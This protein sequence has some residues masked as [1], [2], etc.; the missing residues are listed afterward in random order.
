MDQLYRFTS[1]VPFHLVLATQRDFSKISINPFQQTSLPSVEWYYTV[2]KALAG[3][4][5]HSR[6]SVFRFGVKKSWIFG[7]H[8][9]RRIWFCSSLHWVAYFV[10]LISNLGNETIEIKTTAHN[11]KSITKQERPIYLKRLWPD[12]EELSN[13]GILISKWYVCVSMSS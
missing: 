10:T 11:P 6:A 8:C 2:Y 12:I 4:Y 13:L 1:N 7:W 3:C 9:G 5:F